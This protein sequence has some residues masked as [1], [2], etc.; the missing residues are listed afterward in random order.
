MEDTWEAARQEGNFFNSLIFHDSLGNE[1]RKERQENYHKKKTAK[2]YFL[3]DVF[4]ILIK[5]TFKDFI[6]LL[7]QSGKKVYPK[8]ISKKY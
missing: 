4:P 6:V 7:N 5:S 8:D 2:T 3:I 1:K